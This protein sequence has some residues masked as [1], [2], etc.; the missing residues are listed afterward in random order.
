MNKTASKN[1][2]EMKSRLHDIFNAPTQEMAQERLQ[3]AAKWAEV[4]KKGLGDYIEEIVP[5]GLSIFVLPSTLHKRLK[6]TNLA[7]RVNQELKR[8]T[9]VIRIFPNMEAYERLAG[10]L[11]VQIH[12][13]W[14]EQG[15]KY[16][17]AQLLMETL[18][19]KFGE[20]KGKE[21]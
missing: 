8:R 15:R 16:L 12:D 18:D 13:K 10:S 17:D 4:Q 3:Q 9:R 20:S 19:E 21:V 11:L 2:G 6:T 1:K 14:E 5:Q 7:E